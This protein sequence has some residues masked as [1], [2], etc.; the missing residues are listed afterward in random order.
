MNRFFYTVFKF[1]FFVL[2]HIGSM[3]HAQSSTVLPPRLQQLTER[4]AAQPI[5]RAQFT[6]SKT[7]QGL[8][9]PLLSTGQFLLAQRPVAEG[10]LWRIEQPIQLSYWLTEQHMIEIQ[11][12]GQRQIRRA[13]DMPGF[14][15]IGRI[16]SSLFRL[17]QRDLQQYFTWQYKEQGNDGQEA[18]LLVLTPSAQLASVIRQVRLGGKQYIEWI[19]IDETNQDKLRIQL[20]RIQPAQQLNNEE[21]QLIGLSADGK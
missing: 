21:R 16:M 17:N 4:L 6:Q 9:R 1:T 7:I 12:N 8:Q 15:Q 10:V 14:S 20:S 19:E 18:W 13:S 2:C 3:T 5:L 11:A